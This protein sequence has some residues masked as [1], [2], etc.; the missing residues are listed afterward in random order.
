[1]KWPKILQ[2]LLLFII[3]HT[4]FGAEVTFNK[5]FKGTSTYQVESNSITVTSEFGFTNYRFTSAVPGTQFSGN[6]VNG[7]LTYD[8]LSFSKTRYGTISRLLKTGSNVT[9][10]YFIQTNSSY[11]QTN[12]SQHTAFIFVDPA[13][14]TD[15]DYT[16]STSRSLGTSSDPVDNALNAFLGTQGGTTLDITSTG[17]TTFTSCF[18]T[19]SSSQSVTINGSNLTGSVTV[20]PGSSYQ[21]SLDNSSFSSSATIPLTSGSVSNVLVYIRMKALSASPSSET[22][23]ATSAGVA[24]Q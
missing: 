13:D 11:T 3:A 2:V 15:T 6:N 16:S 20:T 18:N 5:V 19:I 9:A 8:S 4:G 21:V 10:F 14:E 7:Y 12:S 24:D 23:T 22:L 17:L 1:M